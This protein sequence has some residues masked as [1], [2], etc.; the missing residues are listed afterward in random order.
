MAVQI[1]YTVYKITNKLNGK[2]YIGTHKTS[3]LDDNYMGSG[4]NIKR[5]IKKYGSNNFIKEYLAIFDN[6]NEMFEMELKLVNEDFINQDKTYNIIV[7]GK[8]GFKH[9]NTDLTK[10]LEYCKKG[11][12]W[13]TSDKAREL[14]N[15]VSLADK[16]S[17]AKKMGELYG[18]KNKLL[19]CEINERL[20][21]ISNIDLTQY[22]WVT[23]VSECLNLTHTQV[24][25]FIKKH[26]IGNI[27]I[28]KS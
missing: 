22:G 6:P 9:I 12:S 8:G 4:T 14:S 24:R 18:G 7:G 19:E 26:Y 17:I 16:K 23:K 20:D 28:R 13:L 21:K 5:A 25:R 11:G 10:K 1:K 27:Y 2:I 3:N 15:K